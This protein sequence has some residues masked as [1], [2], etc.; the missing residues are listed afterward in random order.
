MD[1][2]STHARSSPP[3]SAG[4]HP[5]SGATRTDTV[6]P[7][8]AKLALRAEAQLLHLFQVEFNGLG[9]QTR[10]AAFRLFK[11]TKHHIESCRGAFGSGNE[12]GFVKCWIA[13]IVYCAFKLS[14]SSDHGK[15][16]FT[17]S[18]LLYALDS[19]VLDFFKELT[20]FL[21]KADSV[22]RSVYG[23]AY[24][25]FLKHLQQL[26]A[27]FV[28][29]AALYDNYEKNFLM[30]FA[31]SEK[32]LEA[33]N[34]GGFSEKSIYLRFGWMLFLSLRMHC[35]DQ[36]VDLMTCAN[37]LIAVFVVMIIHVPARLRK[38][39]LDDRSTY[40]VCS[41]KGVN[42]LS[43]LCHL[44]D[45][46][47][48]DVK[49][50]LAKVNFLIESLVKANQTSCMF[51]D[52]LEQTAGMDTEGLMFFQG[53]MTNDA[54][55]IYTQVLEKEYTELYYKLGG[56]DERLFLPDKG[57]GSA[58]AAQVCSSNS[59]K[60]KYD[61]FSSPSRPL[62]SK[63]RLS[64]ECGT[65]PS[66]TRSASIKMP[67]P[68]PVSVSMS[69][70]KWLRSVIAPLSAEPSQALLAHF[71]SCNESMA[72]EVTSR[73]HILLD[74]VF[75]VEEA[76]GA[77]DGDV[78]TISV[79][80]SGWTSQR[81]LEALKLYFKVLGAMC[82]AEAQRVNSKSLSPLLSNERFH[83]C[84]LACS[85]E[86]VVAT[87]ST[88]SIA[89]PAVLDRMGI[90]AFDLN[91]VIESFVRHEETLPRELKRHLNTVEER[92]LESLAWAKGSSMYNSLIVAK[93]HLKSQVC[94]Q[95]LLADPMP[96]LECLKSQYEGS[97]QKYPLDTIA[98]HA[99]E[100]LQAMLLPSTSSVVSRKEDAPV[101][102]MVLSLLQER[103]SAFSAVTPTKA[104]V[105]RPLHAA[106]ASPQKQAATTVGDAS[107]ETAIS[108]F[109]QKVLKLAAI[110]IKL[111]CGLLKQPSQ[112]MEDIYKLFQHLL[113][114]E[115]RL[116][117]SRHIDQV[118][119]CSLFGVS[120]VQSIKLTFKEI[121]QSYR[122]LPQQKPHVFRAVLLAPTKAGQATGDIIQFYNDV[123]IPS[124]K[125]YLIELSMQSI[126]H[127]GKDETEK[128]EG[129]SVSSPFQSLPDASPRKV[130][131]S[132]NVYVSPL[133]TSRV[134]SPHS[135]RLYACV[136]ES[137]HAFQS[138]S[139]D[140]REIN[141]KLNGRL[142][143]RLDFSDVGLASDPFIKDKN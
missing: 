52:E 14:R 29:L 66:A 46:S 55:N 84:M 16:D 87:Y 37:G 82:E 120:K 105:Q 17:L 114:E 107:A 101:P 11:E 15:G 88:V 76:K 21:R 96:S 125:G 85:V 116:F 72:K 70:A 24:T 71:R 129:I 89:F 61:M 33:T 31:P 42:I 67:P 49:S 75:A 44:Y 128:P 83:R 9:E 57:T 20:C 53:L 58:C 138:P 127:S 28:H 38:V 99:L 65:P 26:Q 30:F 8:T 97:F 62:A 63:A 81:R 56:I 80:S 1:T 123:F 18:K 118:V 45:A 100:D 133:K 10:C 134:L 106:F 94:Q 102:P 93:P 13:S 6:P 22:L 74:L 132:H 95:G 115:T 124:A 39:A 119:L 113:H 140:L 135:R 143:G 141:R 130:S 68:T 3:P 137:T 142:Q 51:I 4:K 108:I 112:L 131:A 73:A 25:E 41:H 92:L 136:G 19:Q 2:C 60:R 23:D 59:A 69:T 91:K 54:I 7:M 64:T 110:R 104:S 78:N 12:E 79:L 43:S 111:I 40:A 90:T 139:K 50:M 34:A 109:L 103:P 98:R 77:A 48:E 122:Q 36:F 117:F 47:E 35:P 5:V 126:S 121:V 86:V 27:N 32:I